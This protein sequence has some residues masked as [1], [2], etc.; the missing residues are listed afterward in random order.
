M[1]PPLASCIAQSSRTRDFT[2][3][4]VGNFTAATSNESPIRGQMPAEI[5]SPEGVSSL[6]RADG[7][8]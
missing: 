6:G 1:P 7:P 5:R 3:G 4:T 8:C 2:V